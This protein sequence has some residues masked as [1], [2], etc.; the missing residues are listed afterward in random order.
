MSISKIRSLLYGTA[1][2]LGDVQ[3]VEKGHIGKRIIRRIA[4]KVTGRILR[5]LVK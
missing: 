2:L 4:G 3:A 1:K 5:K